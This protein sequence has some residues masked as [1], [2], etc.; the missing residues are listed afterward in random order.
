M[1]S[2]LYY[3]HTRLGNP[4]FAKTALLLWDKVDYISPYAGFRPSYED[5]VLAEAA[6]LLTVEHIPSEDEKQE[7]HTE[8]E[9]LVDAKPPDWFMFTPE[10]PN[11]GYLS[12]DVMPEKLWPE[13]WNMLL[14]S[15]LVQIGR[16]PAP[17]AEYGRSSADVDYELSPR[18]YVMTT[19]L[20]LT[21][22]SILADICAGEE[23]ETVTDESDNYAA[24]TRYFTGRSEG[25]YGNVS[26]AGDVA[27]EAK[28]LVT[29]SLKTLSGRAATLQDLVEL[30]KREDNERSPFLWELRRKYFDGIDEYIDRLQKVKKEGDKT[31]NEKRDISEIEREFEV[32]MEADLKNLQQ[33]LRLESWQLLFRKEMLGAVAVAAGAVVEP[34]TTTTISTALLGKALIDHRENKRSKYKGHAM[35]WLYQMHP[36]RIYG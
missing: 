13:T 34:V 16:K 15:Q 35:S 25:K 8:I 9:R 1:Y 23:K 7:A 20:G 26:L 29:I 18:D 31:K 33:E 14:D 3:P 6:E 21:I 24:L 12:Y 36:S 4:E 27:P 32:A 19:S 5:P 17:S 10:N 30:R 2:A 11:L 22:M 28:R